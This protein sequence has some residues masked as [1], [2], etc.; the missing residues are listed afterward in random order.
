MST[1]NDFKANQDVSVM[2]TNKILRLIV[3]FGFDEMFEVK[4]KMM[5]TREVTLIATC[6]HFCTNNIT[7]YIVL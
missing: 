2:F 7:Y 5:L 3:S 1:N 4:I 6:S